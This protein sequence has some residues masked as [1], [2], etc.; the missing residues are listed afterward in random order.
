MFLRK[1]K[2][3]SF[4]Q[5]IVYLILTSVITLVTT[6][7]ITINYV[8]VFERLYIQ[9]YRDLVH[10]VNITTNTLS[11]AADSIS[12]NVNILSGPLSIT[13]KQLAEEHGVDIRNLHKSPEHLAKLKKLSSD[14]LS[15]LLLE[16][17]VTGSFIF[18]DLWYRDDDDMGYYGTYITRSNNNS[19]PMLSYYYEVNMFHS[20][21]E[22]IVGNVKKMPFHKSNMRITPH[23]NHYYGMSNIFRMFTEAVA[24]ANYN[25]SFVTGYWISK[26]DLF[27]NMK[28]DRSQ[29]F[30]VPL[31]NSY[32]NVYAIY[33][34]ELGEERLVEML[35]NALGL[36][37]VDGFFAVYFGEYSYGMRIFEDF[38]RSPYNDKSLSIKLRRKEV[39]NGEELIYS[40]V[41]INGK[42][43]RFYAGI[44]TINFNRRETVG[45]D[46][47]LTIIGFL[48]EDEIRGTYTS[49]RNWIFASILLSGAVSL[50][51]VLFISWS[52]IRDITELSRYIKGFKGNEEFDF[53]KT[54]VLEIDEL[55]SAVEGLNKSVL[56]SGRRISKI[57]DMTKMS[58]GFFED[59]YKDKEVFVTPKLLDII[60]IN[61]KKYPDS[62]MPTEEWEQIFL[63]ILGG[64]NKNKK[65]VYKWESYDDPSVFK[66]LKV[67]CEIVDDRNIGVIVDVTN[68]V[69]KQEKLEDE[70]NYDSMTRLLN[71]KSFKQMVMEQ[72]NAAPNKLGALIFGDLDNL[73]FVND[74]YGHETGDKY[75]IAAADNFNVFKELGGLVARISG[76]EFAIY[77]HGFN[78]VDEGREN[79]YEYIENRT[80]KSILL[81]D[82]V[83]MRINF[84]LGIAW[85]G[86]DSDDIEL[87]MKYAD[88]A[89]YE[90][91]AREKGK[92]REFDKEN[93][94]ETIS[95]L[96]K[97]ENI[98]KLINEK[99]IKHEFQPV[100]SLKDGT[101]YGYEALMRSMS[102]SFTSPAEIISV[103]GSQSKLDKVENLTLS[104]LADWIFNNKEL[105]GSKK[106]FINTTTNQNFSNNAFTEVIDLISEY[107]NNLIFEITDSSFAEIER[108]DEKISQI[109]GRISS[110][111][112]LDDFGAGYGNKLLIT[113]L[114]PDIVKLDYCLINRIFEDKDKQ[115]I[116]K[117]LVNYCKNNGVKV[118]A[119][120]VELEKELYVLIK[121]GVDMA[122]GYYF[123]HPDTKLLEEIHKDKID[124][125]LYFRGTLDQSKKS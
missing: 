111:I 116:V 58:M 34:I 99:L 37:G 121:L 52:T 61:P 25:N 1:N 28:E 108:L 16:D 90:T 75:I 105:L 44:N 39:S 86:K 32:G 101:I 80:I 63:K 20:L 26:S 21:D 104:I 15:S 70:L 98:N 6:F 53:S 11:E 19:S 62:F 64:Y 68:D 4:K 77:I 85:Y 122:Q 118:L 120:G 50:G 78:S 2:A 8:G 123:A 33:G 107:S 57:L 83:E 29:L 66:W 71:K 40:M 48:H 103:A 51:I 74:T 10:R 95:L 60:G 35:Y 112:A 45:D 12:S 119:E 22:Y 14:I 18:F 46:Q 5:R 17:L 38:Y 97:K 43:E 92:V 31:V 56:E 7:T 125:I 110:K 27:L 117:D 13:I 67:E 72:V 106:L 59:R 102:E 81:P 82:R 88:H 55:I 113:S 124:K 47:N 84:S 93:Y 109:R 54:N 96:E 94:N 42:Y 49:S 91:K 115:E 89:M 69:L 100:I 41:N 3:Y 114:K 65:N 87:L 30:I 73:K 23:S 79:I 36:S 24:L 76:D 9:S